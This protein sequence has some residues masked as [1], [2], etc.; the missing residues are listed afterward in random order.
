MFKRKK[1]KTGCETPTYSRFSIAPEP[2]QPSEPNLNYVPPPSVT[3]PKEKEN[4]TMSKIMYGLNL[5]IPFDNLDKYIHEHIDAKYKD[6]IFVPV[7]V[8]VNDLDMSIDIKLLS[9]S[10]VEI[11]NCRHKLDLNKLPKETDKCKD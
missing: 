9:A 11:D 5:Y 3:K 7:K 4:A 6:Q 2:N 10:S 8:E 1:K